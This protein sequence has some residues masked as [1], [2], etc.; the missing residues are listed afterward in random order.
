VAVPITQVTERQAVLSSGEP[1]ALQSAAWQ[2]AVP[3]R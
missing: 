1:V 3:A 2:A